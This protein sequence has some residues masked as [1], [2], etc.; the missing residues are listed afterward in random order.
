M[1]KVHNLSW[2]CRRAY[3]ATWS[4]GPRWRIGSAS[5]SFDH[6]SHLHL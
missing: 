1:K 5:S 4:L 6:P 3:G 2:A